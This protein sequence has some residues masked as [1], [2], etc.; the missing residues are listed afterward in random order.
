M[1]DYYKRFNIF[2]IITINELY[3][4]TYPEITLF[5]QNVKPRQEVGE[6]ALYPLLLLA[7][8]FYQLPQVCFVISNV[9]I[10]DSL[11]NA[12]IFLLDGVCCVFV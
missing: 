12:S 5:G 7:I 2:T 11:Q 1:L 9:N 6:P 8:I 4:S 3:Y 10:V